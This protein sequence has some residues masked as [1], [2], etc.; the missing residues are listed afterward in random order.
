M[1]DVDNELY[2]T[3][4]D[5]WWAPRGP[6]A[7]LQQINPARAAYFHQA[8]A[9]LIGDDRD[10]LAQPVQVLD[11]GCG[12]GFLAEALARM[13]YAVSGID[14]SPG[15][16]A[17]ARRHA[18]ASGLRIDYRVA[19][20][21]SL[22]FADATFDLVVSSDFLEHV[23]DR[24]NAVLGEQARVLRRGG[25]LGF[26]TINRTWQSRVV[27]IWLA[28]H[29]LRVAPPRLHAY[30]LF[31][32]IPQLLLCLARH[33][34]RVHEIQG[35][36]PRLHPVLFLTSYLIRHQSG[37]FRIGNDHSIAYIGAGKKG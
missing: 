19:D 34:V 23:S 17:A 11:V 8:R 1:P 32:P 13:G 10:L 25:V 27:L 12:G 18:S 6:V 16:I 28:Q 20:A 14:R 2:E 5:D 29:L 22:P 7:L 36:V 9:R 24:L 35:L 3:L 30:D 4:G 31:V 21:A 15:S 37:G 26:D 33:D